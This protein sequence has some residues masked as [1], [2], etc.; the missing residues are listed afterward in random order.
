LLGKNARMLYLTQED[1][2]YVGKEKYAQIAARGT[3]SVETRWVRK[4]GRVIDIVLSSTPMDPSNLAASV[5]FTALDI[6]L[7]KSMVRDLKDSEERWKFALEGARDGT[8]DWDI[9]N[10]RMF[11]SP[12]WKKM[13]GY[14]EDEIGNDISEWRSR[15]HPDDR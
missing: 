8:F 2:D 12:T 3:G 5:V 1:Y 14:E 15:L 4:D 13:Q 6:T 7:M 10:D 9:G 11:F